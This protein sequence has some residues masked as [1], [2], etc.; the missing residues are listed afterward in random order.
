[1]HITQGGYTNQGSRKNTVQWDEKFY[2]FA[3]FEE[4]EFQI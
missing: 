1:M 3:R 4:S 2:R